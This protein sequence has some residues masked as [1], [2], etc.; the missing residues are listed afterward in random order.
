MCFAP[1]LQLLLALLI[2][3]INPSL[4]SSTSLQYHSPLRQY[5]Q[6]NSS[7]TTRPTRRTFIGRLLGIRKE[8]IEGADGMKERGGSGIGGTELAALAMVRTKIVTRMLKPS[9]ESE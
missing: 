8:E 3:N 9:L 1:H 6:P 7:L 2:P 4:S 5:I